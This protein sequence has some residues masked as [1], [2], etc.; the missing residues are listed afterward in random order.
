MRFASAIVSYV[1]RMSLVNDP[2]AQTLVYC[3]TIFACFIAGK[4]AHV[5]K[6]HYLCR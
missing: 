6:K 3:L 1:S 2:T 5:K 4:F